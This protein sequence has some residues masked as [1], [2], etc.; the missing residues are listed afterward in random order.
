MALA[1]TFFVRR[2]ST[3]GTSMILPKNHHSNA[4]TL[5]SRLEDPPL[6]IRRSSFFP[7]R[8]WTVKPPA[9]TPIDRSH[10]LAQGLVF[11]C[12]LNE[13]G[14]LNVTEYATG[15]TATTRDT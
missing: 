2:S 8:S 13:G 12:P 9:G 11:A 15:S 3:R 6:R 14:G 10:S 5:A 4:T 1:T 7:G